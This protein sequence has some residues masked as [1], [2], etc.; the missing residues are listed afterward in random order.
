[1]AVGKPNLSL[2]LN[3]SL[4]FYQWVL[5]QSLGLAVRG[6]PSIMKFHFQE[7]GIFLVVALL[8]FPF[9]PTPRLQPHVLLVF[10]FFM[11]RV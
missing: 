1:M 9:P 4:V 7:H 8:S 11:G 5:S 10:G 3:E 6:S 2:V